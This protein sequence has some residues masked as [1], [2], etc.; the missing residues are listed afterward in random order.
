MCHVCVHMCKRIC[1]HWGLLAF[2]VWPTECPL[3][4]FQKPFRKFYQLLTYQILT[5]SL[6]SPFLKMHAHSSQ[7]Q[8]WQRGR[9]LR[10]IN[11]EQKDAVQQLFESNGWPWNFEVTD[12]ECE[13]ESTALS[14]SLAKPCPTSLC[15]NCPHFQAFESWNQAKFT[16]I[17]TMIS[18]YKAESEFY[19]CA[20]CH[21]YSSNGLI[22]RYLW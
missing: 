14:M 3:L 11:R 16:F 15:S 7:S 19:V 20:R 2:E 9:A 6:T 21:I 18:R 5:S 1:K 10:G 4:L 12:I 8:F 22:S 17:T 13:T